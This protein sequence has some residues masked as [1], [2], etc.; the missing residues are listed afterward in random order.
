MIR[1]WFSILIFSIILAPITI[2]NEDGVGISSNYL[3]IILIPILMGI[4]IIKN[5][6][7]IINIIYFIIAYFIGFILNITYYNMGEKELVSQALSLVA[8]T[9]PL[10]FLFYNFENQRLNFEKAVILCSTVYSIFA[11]FVFMD[12]WFSEKQDPFLIKENMGE[13][14]P[15]WPQRYV[16]VIFAGFYFSLSN[17]NKGF[18]AKLTS[19]ILFIVIILTY[20]RAAYL[21]LIVSIFF[22][23]FYKLKES[24]KIISAKLIFFYSAIFF[25]IILTIENSTLVIL[26]YVMQTVYAQFRGGDIPASDQ[27]R[28]NI[29]SSAIDVLRINPITGNGGGGIYLYDKDFGSYHSQYIDVLTRFGIIGLMIYFYY[30]YRIFKNSKKCPANMA[31]LIAYLVFGFAHETVKFSYGAVIFYMILSF[32]YNKK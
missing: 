19:F 23:C 14:L 15:D 7:A 26:D 9:L 22:Y 28:I 13:H 8:A 25:F 27:T 4:N 31:I 29:W 16:L 24:I 20:L 30:N 3:F 12:A 17:L 6:E 21:A 1:D 10:V 2:A 5:N 18:T 32:T 11:V